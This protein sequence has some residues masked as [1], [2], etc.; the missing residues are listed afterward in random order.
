MHYGPR[1][2]FKD[3]VSCEV[4]LIETTLSTPTDHLDV[5]VVQFLRSI[6]DFSSVEELQEQMQ[7]DIQKARD[8]LRA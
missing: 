4:H 6:R 3:T 2:V 5:E 8:I 7:E 1:P